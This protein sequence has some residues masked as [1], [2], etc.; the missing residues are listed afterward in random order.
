MEDH[1][2]WSLLRTLN[3]DWLIYLVQVGRNTTH[4]K[5]DPTGFRTHDM[6]VIDSTYHVPEMLILTTEPSEASSVMQ[7]WR[8][9]VASVS[10]VNLSAHVWSTVSYGFPLTRNKLLWLPVVY[11]SQVVLEE[12]LSYSSRCVSSIIAC[13]WPVERFMTWYPQHFVCPCG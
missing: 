2:R 13:Q 11:F 6:Q 7:P 1:G 3:F 4:P 9:Y 5:F 8:G 12:K 10:K